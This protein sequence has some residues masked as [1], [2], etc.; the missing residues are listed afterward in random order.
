MERIWL[1][2][3]DEKSF[4]PFDFKETIE[5]MNFLVVPDA[6]NL[7]AFLIEEM[8]RELNKAKETDLC[9]CIPDDVDFSNQQQVLTNFESEYMK[10]FN[11]IFSHYFYSTYVFVTRCFG[12]GIV[13]YDYTIFSM[14]IFPLLE[15][16]RYC[17]L[18]GRIPQ[19]FYN[20]YTL[21]I[22]DCL[23]YDQK[24][25]TITGD[26]QMYCI[27]CRKLADFSMQNRIYTAPPIFIFVLN[28]GK[29][30]LD[31]QEKFEFWEIIDLTNYTEYKY[32][33][34]KYF[35]VGVISHIGES[36][37]GHFFA[38]CRM[39]EK[40]PWF[41]YNDSIVSESNFNDINTRGTPYILFYQKIKLD[42]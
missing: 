10:K 16:K 26:N 36:K 8:H 25:E 31:F 27:K 2:K 39:S 24:K 6:K 22:E 21:N 30:N 4:A 19:L 35:L 7:L 3:K 40:S 9:I 42:E 28:R 33:D 1:P 38:F 5:K 14:R 13:R 11:S 23:I 20:Q 34:N 17:V 15:A 18:S 32:P 37:G 29:G 12:C 41:Y